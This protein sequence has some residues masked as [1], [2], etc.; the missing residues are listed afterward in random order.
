MPRFSH[1]SVAMTIALLFPL[2]AA[3]APKF[4][5]LHSFDP[6]TEGTELLY[7]VQLGPQNFLYGA[8][9]FGG[10]DSVGT[11][12][13]LKHTGKKDP[14]VVL[15]HTFTDGKDGAFPLSGLAA[16]MN[17]R[18]F[19]CNESGGGGDGK[20]YLLEP[21]SRDGS[22]WR[23]KVIHEFTGADGSLPLGTPLV[24]PDGDVY[25]TTNEGGAS[26]LGTVFKLSQKPG[27]RW[28]LTV[29]YSF[30]GPDGANPEA[31][32]TFGPHGTLYGTTNAGG[33]AGGGTVFSLQPGKDRKAPWTETVLHSFS[34]GTDG[35]Q[36]L[37]SSVVMDKSG[38]LYGTTSAG[39]AFGGGVAFALTPPSGHGAWK[40]Q[41]LHAF[42]NDGAD[43]AGVPF[44]GVAIGNGGILYGT[45][46]SGG[47][48]NQ[49][50]VYA[51]APPSGTAGWFYT[52][53]HD[54]NG[55]DGSGPEGALTVD[56]AGI[57]YGTATATVFSIT[58]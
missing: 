43:S 38:A 5:V 18:L 46:T 49:G 35:I 28:T 1:A 48:N 36:P 8:A 2:C 11:A 24:S 6:E 10:A 23:E 50:A 29:L 41:I 33:S 57:V 13:A 37:R 58:P 56:E 19:G 52:D 4:T 42:G 34:N 32:L 44:N 45:L 51:L 47:S 54:F 30:A 14:R 26:N 40:E 15:L 17:G 16:D 12:F 53:L 21:R 25:G 27:G 9:N 31:A 20:V 55:T 7:G 3:A 22:K 39:G